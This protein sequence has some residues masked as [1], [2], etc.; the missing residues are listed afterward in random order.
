MV[1][2]GSGKYIITL[3]H[4]FL[5]NDLLVIIT[6]GDAHIGGVSLIENDILSTISK[7]NHKDTVI[8]KIVASIIFNDLKK[9]VLVICGIHIDDIT[10]DEIDILINNTK[11][12]VKQFLKQI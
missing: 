12:C 9:D 3:K 1:Y 8:S 10:K 6:G 2:Y 7:Q 5:G 4:L 11:N